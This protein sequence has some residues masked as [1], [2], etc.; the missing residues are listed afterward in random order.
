MNSPSSLLLP[1]LRSLLLASLFLTC[2]FSCS[3]QTKEEGKVKAPDLRYGF[4]LKVR[5]A[6]EKVFTDTTQKF[7]FE[8]YLDPNKNKVV[9]ISETGAIAVVP[10]PANLP[11]GKAK[12]P[13]WQDA[14][15][16]RVRKANEGNFTKDTKKY[17]VEVYRDEDAGN[18]I[19]ITE[20]GSIA[21]VPATGS[22]KG[23]PEDPVWKF[24]MVLKARKAGEKDFTGSTKAYGIEVFRDENTN[25]L[26]YIT[27]TGD[28]S[29]L[30][31]SVPPIDKSKTP[32]WKAAME[33]KVRKGGDPDFNDKT[34][35]MGVE[36]FLDTN[37]NKLV[38]LSETG[39]VSVPATLQVIGK[40]VPDWQYGLDLKVR[41][42][43]EQDL[44]KAKR[45]GIE[46]FID[47]PTG[48]LFYIAETGS[49]AAIPK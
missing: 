7:G 18:L 49:I 39:Y 44:S 29:V 15:E 37:T 40:G 12:G 26:I 30:P 5:K 25:N 34:P 28:I 8:V 27:D 2:T 14:M 6:G 19:Y 9:Y 22:A 36:L 24:A 33:L 23:K 32:D 38:Y 1:G 48:G 45:V 46:I 10:V 35:K 11:T 16:L 17:G 13:V 20:T 42:A 41:K 31:G 21:V 4:D 47:E 3:A 43:G